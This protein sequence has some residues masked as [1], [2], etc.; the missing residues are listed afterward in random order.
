MLSIF[1]VNL[2]FLGD[3]DDSKRILL[4]LGTTEY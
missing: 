1:N 4:W 3:I 2:Y